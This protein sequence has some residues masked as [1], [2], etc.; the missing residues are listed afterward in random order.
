CGTSAEFSPLQCILTGSW[1]NDLGSNMTIS[2][3][4]KMGSFDGIYHTAVSATTE[5]IKKSPLLGYQ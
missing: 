3:V 1:K 4:S 5:K 2:D